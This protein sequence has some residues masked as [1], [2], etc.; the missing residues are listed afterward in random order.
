MKRWFFLIPVVAA[1]ALWLRPMPAI[2]ALHVCN[3][4]DHEIHV[5]VGTLSGD[6]EKTACVEHS[7]GW[8]NIDPGS[9][10]TPIGGSLDTSGDTFYYYY[11]EDSQGGTWTGSYTFCVDP[12]YKFDYGDDANMQCNGT[13][14]SFRRVNNGSS[15]EYTVSLTP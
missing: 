2:A 15:G 10:K 12:E 13:H 1:C 14:R 9:C 4:T 11:A 3:K 7:K 5:A 8:W 6:C